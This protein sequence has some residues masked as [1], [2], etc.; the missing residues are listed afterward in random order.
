MGSM[1]APDW[2]K[3]ET[4]SLVGFATATLTNGILRHIL[5]ISSVGLTNVYHAGLRSDPKI[6]GM[7]TRQDCSTTFSGMRDLGADGDQEQQHGGNAMVLKDGEE[8]GKEGLEQSKP[9]QGELDEGK[10]ALGELAEGKPAQ[11]EP[12]QCSLAQE[13]TEEAK[14]G[15]VKEEAM[16]GGHAAAGSS[17]PVDNEVHEEGGQ[18][19]SGAQQQ[20]QQEGAAAMPEGANSLQTRERL[21]VRRRTRFTL[22]QLQDLEQLFQENRHPSL[23]MRKDL[24][25]WLG[26]SEEDVQD[27]FRNRRAICRRNTRLLVLCSTPPAPENSDA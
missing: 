19:G 24:A 9:A 17:G 20:P 10:L 26:V 23:H 8:G 1:L 4:Q 15:E 27:W 25:R 18:G 13:A 2:T 11:E 7:E 22:S 3:V 12:A 16:G 21:P 6:P 14:E 5:G